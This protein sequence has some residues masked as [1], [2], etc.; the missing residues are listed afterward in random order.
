[1]G[2]AER[3]RTSWVLAPASGGRTSHDQPLLIP[4]SKTSPPADIPCFPCIC[5]Q[6]WGAGGRQRRHLVVPV[7]SEAT[8]PVGEGVAP[9]GPPPPARRARQAACALTALA[10]RWPRDKAGSLR[11]PRAARRPAVCARG[12]PSPHPCAPCGLPLGS[13]RA[14]ASGGTAGGRGRKHRTD[15]AARHVLVP[16]SQR[17]AGGRGPERGPSLPPAWGPNVQPVTGRRT[18]TDVPKSPQRVAAGPSVCSRAPARPVPAWRLGESP[19]S[20][21]PCVPTAPRAGAAAETWART[22]APGSFLPRYEQQ[23]ERGGGPGRSTSM[24]AEVAAGPG[25]GDRPLALT[26]S[27]SDDA[28]CTACR[29]VTAPS[30]PTATTFTG[31]ATGFPV[32]MAVFRISASWGASTGRL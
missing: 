2:G 8:G 27:S 23:G 10:R 15:G 17:R 9:P 13:E 6:S 31:T 32:R 7:S 21:G 19:P 26:T 24:A 30:S 20:G 5:A 25:R 28:H 1:M 16:G 29:S 11:R 22:P 14:E 12:R 4:R 18:P 3:P